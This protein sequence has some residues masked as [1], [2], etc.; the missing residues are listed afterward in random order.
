[1]YPIMYVVHAELDIE[2]RYE[3][4]TRYSIEENKLDIVVIMTLLSELVVNRQQL[5]LP[6]IRELHNKHSSYLN[7]INLTPLP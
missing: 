1:M 5:D 4:F 3:I 6:L 7:T 2:L